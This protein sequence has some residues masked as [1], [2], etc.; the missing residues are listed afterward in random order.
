MAFTVAEA[1]NTGNKKG[2]KHNDRVEQSMLLQFFLVT[3]S[4]FPLETTNS[5]IPFKLLTG[6]H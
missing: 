1:E 6:K 4:L 3:F 2:Y 5:Q